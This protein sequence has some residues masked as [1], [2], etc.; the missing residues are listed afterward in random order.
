MSSGFDVFV[1]VCVFTV[2]KSHIASVSFSLIKD[3]GTV[4]PSQSLIRLKSPVLP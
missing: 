2:K 4:C 3:I 1:C